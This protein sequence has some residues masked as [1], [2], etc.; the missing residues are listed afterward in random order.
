MPDASRRAWNAVHEAVTD[1]RKTDSK[2][3]IFLCVDTLAAALENTPVAVVSSSIQI[4][5]GIGG[6]EG[7]PLP[8]PK[9]VDNGYDPTPSTA[10]KN[11]LR[12][13][14]RTATAT[15]IFKLGGLFGSAVTQVDVAGASVGGSAVTTSCMHLVQIE[16][17]SKKARYAGANTIQ[18]WCAALRK[19]K[20]ARAAIAGGQT[21]AALIPIPIASAVLGGAVGLAAMAVKPTLVHLCYMTAIEIHW[22]AFVEQSLSSKMPIPR[23]AQRITGGPA[24]PASELYWEI[25]QRRGFTRVFGQDDVASMVGEPGGWYPLSQKLLEM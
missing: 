9:F 7:E 19:A 20:M 6:G 2:D 3:A 14:S 13:Q 10:S 25:F 17:I 23:G 21:A 4:L 5:R 1:A 22:R 8:N 18:G 16:A 15:G 24:G 12:R 11:F